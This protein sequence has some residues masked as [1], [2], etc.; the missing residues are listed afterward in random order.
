[1]KGHWVVLATT[2]LVPQ[3]SVLLLILPV[4]LSL[5]TCLDRSWYV[6]N[7]IPYYCTTLSDNTLNAEPR[8]QT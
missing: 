7:V 4:T 5:D 3:T 6:C 1:M 2:T 8:N